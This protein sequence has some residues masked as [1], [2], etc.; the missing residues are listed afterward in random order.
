MAHDI[1]WPT[2][3]NYIDHDQIGLMLK[4]IYSTQALWKQ[5]ETGQRF[6]LAV[7]N[8]IAVGFIGFQPKL[9]NPK[10][11]RIEKLYVSQSEQGQGTGK[12]L[13]NHV[14]QTAL[15]AGY[16]YLELNVN[17]NNPAVT[18]YGRQ[19]F[20]TVETVDIP[21]HGYMLNDYVM[22]KKLMD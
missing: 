13:I 14:A 15:A 21:Y 9:G 8:D 7:R 16:S 1:W 18:F 3:R 10:V 22:Q 4:L 11:M 20:V 12:L 2:Y 6:S 5:L 17:R 19:G